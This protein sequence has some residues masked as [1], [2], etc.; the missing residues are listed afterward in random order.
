MKKVL[1]VDWIHTLCIEKNKWSENKAYFKSRKGCFDNL[2]GERALIV[3]PVTAYAQ[4][5]S[6][7][8]LR[9]VL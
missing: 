1:A 9:G 6:I 8:N 7:L 4:K 5:I 3:N 2:I